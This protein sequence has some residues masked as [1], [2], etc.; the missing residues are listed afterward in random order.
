MRREE[1]TELADDLEELRDA[2]CDVAEGD[3]MPADIAMRGH[4]ALDFLINHLESLADD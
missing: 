3:V 2:L 4:I 1:L